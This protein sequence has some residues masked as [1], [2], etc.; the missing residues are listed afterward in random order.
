MKNSSRIV[1][2]HEY[3]EIKDFICEINKEGKLFAKL[4]KDK[5]ELPEEE[6]KK[7]MKKLSVIEPSDIEVEKMYF[8]EQYE[9]TV[10]EVCIHDFL[11]YGFLKRK[12]GDV[13]YNQLNWKGY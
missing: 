12:N 13:D 8:N 6:L 11:R 7:L 9:T 4:P 5:W 3:L 2:F 1:P 10:F